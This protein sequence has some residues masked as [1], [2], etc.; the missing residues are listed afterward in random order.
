[1]TTASGQL[2][3]VLVQYEL[4]IITRGVI[5]YTSNNNKSGET[6]IK[7]YVVLTVDSFSSRVRA[8]AGKKIIVTQQAH[9]KE[10]MSSDS[11]AGFAKF[12]N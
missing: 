1:M 9:R 7:L 11:R 8:L 10:K 2:V 3:C 12:S 4:I 6:H 5:I